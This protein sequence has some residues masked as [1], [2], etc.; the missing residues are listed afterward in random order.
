[1]ISLKLMMDDKDTDAIVLIGEIGGVMEADVA[2]WVKEH[3]DQAC[4]RVHCR[5]DGSQRDAAWAMQE[6]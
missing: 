2:Y 1:M 6:L 3:G 4:D 5:T